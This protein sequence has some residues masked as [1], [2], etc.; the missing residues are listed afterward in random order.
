M[1]FICI[2]YAHL[3]RRNTYFFVIFIIVR[4]KNK[5]NILS[6]STLLLQVDRRIYY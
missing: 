4:K 1:L 5:L 6:I 3:H 2:I